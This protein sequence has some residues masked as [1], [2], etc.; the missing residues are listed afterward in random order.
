MTISEATPEDKHA[1]NLFV[2]KNYPP[3]GAF[4]QTWEWGNFQKNLG[5]RVG[6]YIVTDGDKKIAVF[7]MVQFKLPMGLY[8][9]YIP[10]G[11]VIADWAT[12][13]KTVTALLGTIKD[14]VTKKFPHLIF[15]RLEPPL[16]SFPPALKEIGFRFPHQYVQPR[17]NAVVSLSG[18]EADVLASFHPSTRSNLRRAEKRGVRVTTRTDIVPDDYATFVAMKNDTIKRNRGKNAFPNDTYFQSFF[19]TIPL[20]GTTNHPQNLSVDAFYG[21]QD[22]EPASAHFVLF[23]GK[24]A[25]YLYGATHT[26]HLNSKVDTYLHWAA[27][28]EALRRGFTYYDLGGIDSTRW[29]TLTNF[30][31]QFRGTEMDYAGNIDIPLR[32]NWYKAYLLLKNLKSIT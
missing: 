16:S 20:S 12:N 27:M 7:I 29:P 32:Q 2:E 28:R 11:P 5:R 30:K 23:F 3:V 26:R 10:R 17:Y 15:L 4:M 22:N 19:A 21:Y 9:G 1:W 31:R 25:T 18:S 14:W 8:Y 13:S 6:R 24:T